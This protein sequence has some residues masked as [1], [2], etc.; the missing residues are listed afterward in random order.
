MVTNRVNLSALG[1]HRIELD[2]DLD[3]CCDALLLLIAEGADS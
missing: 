2:V 3:S 1:K